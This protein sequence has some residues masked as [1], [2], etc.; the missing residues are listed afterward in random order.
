MWLTP[1]SF[2][3]SYLFFLLNLHIFI[4]SF[5]SHSGSLE[6]PSSV[7]NHLLLNTVLEF[8]FQLVYI[9]TV[10]FQVFSL[11]SLAAVLS[12]VF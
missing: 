9:F 1:P 7:S 12:L 10:G 2:M 4:F 6:L 8:S 11:E 5:A 3:P